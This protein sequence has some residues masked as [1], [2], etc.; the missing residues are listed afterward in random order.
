VL[1]TFDS[2]KGYKFSLF[3]SLGAKGIEKVNPVALVDELE[4]FSFG[5]VPSDDPHTLSSSCVQHLPDP[6]KSASDNITVIHGNDKVCGSSDGTFPKENISSSSTSATGF[7]FSMP[8]APK[9]KNK[10]NLYPLVESNVDNTAETL[11]TP[12]LKKK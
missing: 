1:S 5:N 8:F 2:T 12:N 4:M 3:F 10:E 11:D 9:E 7:T 6:D